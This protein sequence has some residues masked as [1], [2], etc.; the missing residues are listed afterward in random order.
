MMVSVLLGLRPSGLLDEF[1][2]LAAYVPAAKRGPHTNGPSPPNGRST[3][4]IRK[5]ADEV[6]HRSPSSGD[7][8]VAD[9]RPR[10]RHEAHKQ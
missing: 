7:L 9:I 8:A 10:Y 5:L 1:P 2:N 4:G 6:L 3:P